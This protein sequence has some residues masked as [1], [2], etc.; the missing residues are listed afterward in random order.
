M[1][2]EGGRSASTLEVL[3]TS[4]FDKVTGISTVKYWINALCTY[5]LITLE[6]L[7]VFFQRGMK[8]YQ[9]LDEYLETVRQHQTGRLCVDC[10]I[11]PNLIAL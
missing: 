8:K 3:L 11:N 5:R 6:L 2:F 4:A 1:L 9:E 7:Q 10:P